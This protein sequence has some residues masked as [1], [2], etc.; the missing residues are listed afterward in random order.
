MT[1]ADSEAGRSR[2][3]RAEDG[4]RRA[5]IET[6]HA[7]AGLVAAALTPD[8]TDSMATTVDGDRVVTTVERGT[9][10]GLGSSVDDYVVNLTVAQTVVADARS[11]REAVES[12]DTNADADDTDHATEN[13]EDD[14]NA[15]STQNA[16]TESDTTPQ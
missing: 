3:T 12:M 4:S 5:R 8:N 10:G 13:S 15:N 6:R 16:D 2:T 14:E 9:T 1:G 7:D 11:R